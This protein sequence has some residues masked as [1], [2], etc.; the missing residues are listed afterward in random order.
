MDATTHY[1]RRIEGVCPVSIYIDFKSFVSEDK[2]VL[3]KEKVEDVLAKY[4]DTFDVDIDSSDES[5]VDL[6]AS[7]NLS[8][9]LEYWSGDRIN[10]PEEDVRWNED[11]ESILPEVEKELSKVKNYDHVSVFNSDIDDFCIDYE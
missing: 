2:I 10:P 7:I 1:V 3:V 11:Y 8:G 5:G 6:S 4:F 9:E